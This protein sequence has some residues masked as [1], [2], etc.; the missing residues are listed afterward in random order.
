MDGL[1]EAKW[2]FCDYTNAFKMAKNSE[3]ETNGKTLK[4]FAICL[5][6]KIKIAEYFR[7]RL[8][9]KLQVETGMLETVPTPGH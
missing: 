9:L 2:Q 5:S 3:S 1:E 8:S 4:S 6:P 7:G